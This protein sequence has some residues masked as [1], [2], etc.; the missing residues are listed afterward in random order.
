M[1]TV[2][3]GIGFLPRQFFEAHDL[4]DIAAAGDVRG[5]AAMTR[6]AAMTVA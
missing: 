1:A 4:G 3:A 6:L 5:S 2:A